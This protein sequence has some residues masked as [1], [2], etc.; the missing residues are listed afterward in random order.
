MSLMVNQPQ[1]GTRGST[2]TTNIRCALAV[3][4]LV[5]CGTLVGC[6]MNRQTAS[7]SQRSEATAEDKQ[8]Q[9]TDITESVGITFKH[10][11]GAFGAKL[12]PES[13]GSGAAF[14]DYNNDGYQ[15]LFLVNGRTWTDEE[16]SAHKKGKSKTVY[17]EEI[18]RAAAQ[19]S[20]RRST[21]TL[22]HNNGDGTFRDVTR[23]S[24]LDVEMFGMGATVGDYDNDGKDDLYVTGY[25]RNYLF[26]NEGRGRFREVA[27][28]SGV[29]D[30]G[31]STSAA[32]L[33]FDRDGWL[34]LFVCHYVQW[35]PT[36]DV[37]TLGNTTRKKSY[38]GPNAFR[39]R[40]L[41]P[42]SQS[43]RAH[44]AGQGKVARFTE[45]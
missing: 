2:I 13:I 21:S 6:G 44:M 27:H 15:D 36:N 42:L 10:N 5:G 34:D 22:Y 43:G 45:V 23:G 12:M 32:W 18:V 20:K 26:H 24:G 17:S 41:S 9:F 11:N 28:P 14:I 35:T 33:D 25:G 16:I 3:L 8:I 31:W 37:F 39:G 40:A 7:D 19:R 38:A 29:L 4:A 1:S 30:S